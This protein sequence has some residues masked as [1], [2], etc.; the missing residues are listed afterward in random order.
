MTH[1]SASPDYE[2]ARTRA[3]R[4]RK[5]RGDLVAYAIINAFL[6]GV[7]AITGLGYFWPGWVLGV[8][9]LFLILSASDL[10]FRHDVTAEEIERELHKH[11]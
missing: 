5:W 3:Q 9:G 11:A 4:K 7:W 10:Y 6:I 2:R 8:W 1:T